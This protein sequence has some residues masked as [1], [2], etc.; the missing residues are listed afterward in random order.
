MGG[1]QLR[2]KSY[3]KKACYEQAFKLDCQLSDASAWFEFGDMGGAGEIETGVG[4]AYWA[5]QCKFPGPWFVI[6]FRCF[7]G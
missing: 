5:F 4:Y 2:G 3:S 7:L 1:G 6:E